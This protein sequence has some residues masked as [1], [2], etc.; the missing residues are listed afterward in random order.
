MQK[1]LIQY[2]DSIGEIELT[3]SDDEIKRYRALKT[4]KAGLARLVIRWRW[5]KLRV[6]SSVDIQKYF[7]GW[8]ARVKMNWLLEKPLKLRE[9]PRFRF[10]K[11]QKYLVK[12]ILLKQNIFS[13]NVAQKIFALLM[14]NSEFKLMKPVELD[15]FKMPIH[16]VL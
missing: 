8:Q 12:H 7:R 13:S 9:K 16:G 3:M 14:E 5:K 15:Q 11:E 6:R 1:N 4:L 10:L 2:F